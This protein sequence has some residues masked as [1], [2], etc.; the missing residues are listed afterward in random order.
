MVER[1]HVVEA[2]AMFI[3]HFV[4]A[5]PEV[6]CGAGSRSLLD[7]FDGS[8]ARLLHA[9]SLGAMPPPCLTTLTRRIF[10]VFC[11]ATGSGYASPEAAEGSV[12][13][14][15]GHEEEVCRVTRVC[16]PTCAQRVRLVCCAEN[17]R[18][19]RQRS[20]PTTTAACGRR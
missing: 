11:V 4:A 9:I 10:L 18:F 20:R 19:T 1:E 6:W 5:Q 12:P 3:A 13:R 8:A 17:S 2:I 7:G 16:H 15:K 14:F